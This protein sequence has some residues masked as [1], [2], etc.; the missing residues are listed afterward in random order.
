[1]IGNDWYL[2]RNLVGNGRFYTNSGNEAIPGSARVSRAGEGLWRSRTSLVTINIGGQ[3]AIN[4]KFVSARRRNQTRET[5]ALPMGEV[6]LAAFECLNLFFQ[7][8]AD[9]MSRQIDLADIDS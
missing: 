7:Q 5:R 4:E 6:P 2:S 3:Q 8:R 1:V 9:A